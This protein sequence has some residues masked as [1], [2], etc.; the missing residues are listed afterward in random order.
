M[1][2][3]LRLYT[4]G[5]THAGLQRRSNDDCFAAVPELGLLLVADG[6]GGRP[7]G[8]VAA[9]L[10]VHTVRDAV[11]NPETT[12]P[13]EGAADPEEVCRRLRDAI[14][15][16]NRRV[17]EQGEQHAHLTGMATT[18]VA[19]MVAAGRLWIAHAGDSRAYLLRAGELRRLTA[20]H[21]VA[22]DASLRVRLKPEVLERR[23]A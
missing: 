11:A 9:K 5:G 14:A 13:D 4:G 19:A 2:P 7:A 18:L 21:S 16:A 12:W 10:A 8:D 22:E 17:R 20:D 1:T 3:G 6:V 15:L 23:S